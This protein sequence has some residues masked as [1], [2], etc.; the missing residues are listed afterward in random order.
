MQ[1]LKT[2]SGPVHIFEFALGRES[3]VL[4][5]FTETNNNGNSS[6]LLGAMENSP[7]SQTKVAIQKE[8]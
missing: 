5:I 8:N 3:G 4:D 6:F 7:H 1:T 2:S